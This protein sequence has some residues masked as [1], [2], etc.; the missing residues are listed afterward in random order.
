LA[1]LAA[2]KNLYNVK[3]VFAIN[4]AFRLRK[5]T[6]K[7]APAMV[8]W[9]KLADK[10]VKDESRRHFVPSESENPHI[11]YLRN[12]IIGVKELMDLID[13]A[14]QHLGEISLPVLLIQASDDPVVHP[15]GSKLLYQGLGSED[16]EL[17]DF[18]SDRHGIIR[19]ENSEH[20]FAHV[21]KFLNNKV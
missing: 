16:K 20:V 3:A 2:A 14:S 21:V 4:P 5:R 18:P 13:E 7:F 11:N 12:P 19:G 9:N 8:L 10:L 15:E 17:I 1:L 6:A